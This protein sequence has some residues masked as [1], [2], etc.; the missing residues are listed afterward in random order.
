MTLR[1]QESVFAGF[2]L[3]TLLE[4]KKTLRLPQH[5]L[6]SQHEVSR[7]T[8]LLL[9]VLW[10]P[11]T[12]PLDSSSGCGGGKKKKGG[13]WKKVEGGGR[14]GGVD[15]ERETQSS[16]F[17]SRQASRAWRKVGR[18][19]HLLAPGLVVCIQEEQAGSGHQA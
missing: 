3:L 9:G 7:E 14:S 17:R 13:E 2:C 8:E 6:S 5:P 19:T 18:H 15:T 1:A 16:V 4:R 11:P 12:Q 10:S